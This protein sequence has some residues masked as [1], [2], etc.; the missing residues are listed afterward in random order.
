MDIRQN[1]IFED[2]KMMWEE[3]LDNIPLEPFLVSELGLSVGLDAGRG[4]KKV[5]EK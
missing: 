3:R 1:H 4:T 2:I 5:K